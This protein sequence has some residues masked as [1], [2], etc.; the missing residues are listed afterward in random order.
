MI[1]SSILGAELRSLYFSTDKM[2][3]DQY[4]K[5]I[6]AVLILFRQAVKVFHTYMQDE[7]PCHRENP[8]NTVLIH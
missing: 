1:W 4:K 5:V 6:E 3:Q 8:K 2:K 7:A